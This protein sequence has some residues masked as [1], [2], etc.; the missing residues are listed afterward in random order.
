MM[1][2]WE[3][4]TPWGQSVVA[5]IGLVLVAFLFLWG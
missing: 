4:L 3:M 2:Y 1:R 5:C